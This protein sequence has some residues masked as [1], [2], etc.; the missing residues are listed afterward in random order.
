MPG[1]ESESSEGSPYDSYSG[2]G[3]GDLEME[4]GEEVQVDRAML[5]AKYVL[6][7]SQGR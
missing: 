6:F 7:I 2:A 5:L 1:S 4:V 3:A